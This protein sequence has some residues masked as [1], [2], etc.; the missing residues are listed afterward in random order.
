MADSSLR[1]WWATPL[2]GLLGG[3]LASQVGWPLP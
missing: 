3:Y 2:I 1:Q